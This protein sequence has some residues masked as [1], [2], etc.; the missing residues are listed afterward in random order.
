MHD[1]M[2]NPD[3]SN[4]IKRG[5]LSLCLFILCHAQDSPWDSETGW[6]GRLRLKTNPLKCISIGI[7]L[8]EESKKIIHLI[9]LRFLNIF[10]VVFFFYL[11]FMNVRQ[12]RSSQGCSTITSVTHWLINWFSDPLVQISSKHCQTQSGRVREL[13]FW[14]N[15]YSK[16][17]VTCHLLHNICFIIFF[18]KE[19]LIKK[20]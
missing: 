7:Y 5:F 2:A 17:C 18:I 6:I 20:N 14:E 8:F 4:N 16:L 15:G 3:V 19:K 9:F 13:K 11:F 10:L 12:T 1:T